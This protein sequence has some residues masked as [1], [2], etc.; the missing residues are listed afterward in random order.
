MIG[1]YVIIKAVSLDEA[2]KIAQDCPNL[3]YGGKVEVRSVMS[4]DDDP[5]SHT[6][7]HEK[8]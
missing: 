7:L 1:G 3:L 8:N 6:F 2:V 5:T 4:I